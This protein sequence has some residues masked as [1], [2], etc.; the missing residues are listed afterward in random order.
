MAAPYTISVDSQAPYGYPLEVDV[1][2]LGASWFMPTVERSLNG[3]AWETLWEAQDFE[4]GYVSMT[5]SQYLYDMGAQV[6][7]PLTND[8]YAQYRVWNEVNAYSVSKVIRTTPL[9]PSGLRL[10]RLSATSVK[11][12]FSNATRAATATE[13]W[14]KVGAGA[15]T[16]LATLGAAATTY[17]DA[18]ASDATIVYKV[19]NK[20]AFTDDNQANTLYSDYTPD[21]Q[22]TA[23]AA[24]S[25]PT[26]LTPAA[27]TVD[28]TSGNVRFSWTPSH[29]D[30]SAQSAFE[31]RY[32]KVGD[33]GWTSTGK[34]VSAN[35][36]YDVAA[37]TF[38]QGNSYEWQVATYGLSATEG[39]FAA[40]STFASEHVPVCAI[41][42][43]TAAQ[44][45]SA[46]PFNIA[47]TFTDRAGA[48]QASIVLDVVDSNGLN[49]L[50][51]EASG[52]GTTAALPMNIPNATSF[53][54][55]L[56]VRSSTGLYSTS[57]TRT[58][59]TSWLAPLLPVVTVTPFSA[60]G[61][62][63]F[64]VRFG[65]K[66]GVQGAAPSTTQVDIYRIEADKSLTAVKVGMAD[67]TTTKDSYPPLNVAVSYRAIARAA[68]GVTS[69]LDFS[70]TVTVG[71][72]HL[73]NFGSS[74]G[75]IVAL[76]G[77]IDTSEK[78]TADQSLY[79]FA[80]RTYPVL[81]TGENR[82]NSLTLNADALDAA[83]VTSLR[84]LSKD[85]GRALYRTPDGASYYVRPVVSLSKDAGNSPLYKVSLV[86][87]VLDGT[88]V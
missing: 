43:P 62:L 38:L 8:C 33:V 45:L 76:I 51:S 72:K 13:I 69:Q 35:N 79:A 5:D 48:T 18:A 12:D 56:K 81:Y 88:V 21:T 50:H 27:G 65:E 37:A 42:A 82:S 53:T 63:Q 17:T 59:S 22:V 25:A 83:T 3:G 1:A 15:W 14:R 85:G 67:N 73:I 55:T 49:W 24:P 70:A 11:L 6:G 61:A 57:V 80:G 66:V 19:R 36:Y 7:L 60:S 2:I 40:V 68:N 31:L 86:M 71:R 54:V 87:D 9:T 74:L 23:I 20:A 78:P 39:A 16:L 46:L 77:N 4:A 52:T 32:R 26:L 28:T 64:A 41:T 58:F 34:V 44:V 75:N 29:P 84:G 10:S 30:G 47:W